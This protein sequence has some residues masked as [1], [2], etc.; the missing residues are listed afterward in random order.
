MNKTIVDA[1]RDKNNVLRLEYENKWLVADDS[2]GWIVFE[3]RP[4]EKIGREILRTKSERKAISELLK[5]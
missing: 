4:D 2:D 1:M 5:I 3:A